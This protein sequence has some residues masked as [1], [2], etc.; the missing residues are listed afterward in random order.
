AIP[1]A[2]L[3]ALLA[4]RGRPL[5]AA[6]YANLGVVSQTRTELGLYEHKQFATLTLDRVRQQVDL[7]EALGFFERALELDVTQASARTRWSHVAFD[8]ADYGAALAQA[9]AAW[10]AGQRDRVTRLVYGDALVA[11]GRIAEAAEVVRGLVWADWRLQAQ[12]T[13]QYQVLDDP[14]RAAYAAEA[15]R[16]LTAG[17]DSAP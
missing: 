7:D 8:R 3:L 2:L 10:E 5:L 1:A 15:Y 11:Q 16:L 14:Q 6:G 17:R 4:W 9:Q 12:A 13:Y